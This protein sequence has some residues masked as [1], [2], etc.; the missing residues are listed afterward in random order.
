MGVGDDATGHGG[1]R[2]AVTTVLIV[3]AVL[4]IAIGGFLAI[5]RPQLITVDAA[6]PDNFPP[7]GFS[8]A[9]FD[10]LM[11]RY[12]DAAGRVDYDAWHRDAADTLSLSEY[13]AAV[14]AFSPSNTPERFPKQSDR[15]AYWLNAYNAYVIFG[16]L[17]HWPIESV[18]DVRAPIEAM[19]GLGF[20]WRQRFLFG[21]EAL[22]LYAVENDII[23]EQFRDPRIHFVLNC[24]SESCPVARPEIP[25]G[26]NLEPLLEQATLEFLSD[27]QNI[28]IDHDAHTIRISDIFKWYEK[29]FINDLRHRGL[30]TERGLIDYL[31]DAAPAGLADELGIAADYELGFIGYDWSLNDA[32]SGSK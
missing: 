1:A 11:T 5:N 7:Q 9:D 30:S 14:A 31:V 23:R 20:F 25:T 15:L 8:H 22:S 13:L 3:I 17:E 16:V 27:P 28:A 29:D 19:T 6:L 4:A 2:R 32:A 24:A 26:E 12:V 10:R 18:T 21:G